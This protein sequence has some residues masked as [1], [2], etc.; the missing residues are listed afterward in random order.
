M[1]L[2]LFRSHSLRHGCV[3]NLKR[4]EVPSSE[5]AAHVCMSLYMWENVYGME[6]AEDVGER[7]TPG[8]AGQSALP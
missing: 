8:I 5:G 2:A 1:P 3:H 6:G 4:Q 7:V